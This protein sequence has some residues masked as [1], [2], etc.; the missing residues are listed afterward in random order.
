MESLPKSLGAKGQQAPSVDILVSQY[1]GKDIKI[2]LV[3]MVKMSVAM[4]H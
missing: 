4:G 1:Q 3:N 2:A